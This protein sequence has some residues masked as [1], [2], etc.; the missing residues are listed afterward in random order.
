MRLAL[1][2]LLLPLLAQAEEIAPPRK[3]KKPVEIAPIDVTGK[4]QVPVQIVIPRN[5]D[6]KKAVQSAG[7][8][9]LLEAAERR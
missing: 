2:A 9:A 4:R 3:T 7:G 6:A 1:V 8:D 5:P